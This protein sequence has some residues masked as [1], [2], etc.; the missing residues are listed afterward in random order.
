MNFSVKK[1]KIQNLKVG[2]PDYMYLTDNKISKLSI[3]NL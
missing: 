3:S 2:I 1:K